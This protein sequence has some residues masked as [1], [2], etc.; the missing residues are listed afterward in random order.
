[1]NRRTACLTLLAVFSSTSL[2][3]TDHTTDSLELVQKNLAEKKA[4]LVD[5]RELAEWNK[6]HLKDAQLQ[7]LSVLDKATEDPATR[8]K[9]LKELPK[10]RIVYC[11]CARGARAKTAGDILSKLGYDVR[12]LAAGFEELRTKGF[13]AAAPAESK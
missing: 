1:M 12:P 5:V 3:A 2:F 4:V 6:G 10:D 13:E 9:L 8:E 7:P 11:H